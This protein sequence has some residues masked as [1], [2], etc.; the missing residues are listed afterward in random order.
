MRFALFEASPLFT[1]SDMIGKRM[2]RMTRM[3]TDFD[4]PLARPFPPQAEKIRFYPFN[5]FHPFSNPAALVE[6]NGAATL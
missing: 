2:T 5:P 3:R 1:K 6:L 4:S